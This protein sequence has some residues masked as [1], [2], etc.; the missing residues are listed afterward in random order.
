MIT[1]RNSKKSFSNLIKSEALRLGFFKCGISIARNLDEEKDRL[2]FWLEKKMNGEMFYMQ[3]H[4]E[5]RLD[6]TK[7]VPG[8][9]SVISVL[10]NYYPSYTLNLSLLLYVLQSHD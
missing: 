1:K 7:L 4:F 10:L 3:N 8:A 9:K 2:K 6:P 5:K